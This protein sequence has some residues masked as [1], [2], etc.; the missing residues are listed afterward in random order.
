[1]NIYWWVAKRT[2][3]LEA[4]SS[5]ER[6]GHGQVVSKYL[7]WVSVTHVAAI[8]I[9]GGQQPCGATLWRLFAEFIS[10]GVGKDRS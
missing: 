6:G 2:K 4:S 1:M 8:K 9:N 10:Q 5:A 3:R 7:V